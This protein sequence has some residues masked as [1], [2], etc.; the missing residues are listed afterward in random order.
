M[1][2]QAVLGKLLPTW[3]LYLLMAQLQGRSDLRREQ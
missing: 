3:I 1:D 2:G